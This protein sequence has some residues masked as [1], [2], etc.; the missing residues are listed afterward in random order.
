MGKKDIAL[1]KYLNDKERFS[2]LINGILFRGEQELMP[3]MLEERDSVAAIAVNEKRRLIKRE[4]D[5]IHKAAMGV[6]F[7]ILA[8]EN[9]M[10]IHY[11]MPVRIM[12]YDGITYEEQMEEL[13]KKNKIE[14]KYK[15]SAE[16]LSGMKKD[17]VL[18]PVITFVLYYG[19]DEWDDH[20]TLKSMLKIPSKYDILNTYIND[21]KV[22]LISMR[23]I[24]PKLFKGELREF[25]EL[26][27][28]NE[29]LEKMKQL[30]QTDSRYRFL[31]KDTCETLMALSD[32]MDYFERLRE[33]VENRE[34]FNMSTAFD[35][36]VQQGIDQ[37]M[38][39]GRKQQLQSQI[40]KKVE[41]G[42]SAEVIAEQLEED[43][44]TIV[45]LMKENE[46]N[47]TV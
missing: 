42:F 44:D 40:R 37:G 22:N 39:I 7:L 8:C 25:L 26:L 45:A 16:F 17:D 5:I 21:S 35:Q 4:R 34:V 18:I 23:K 31:T 24:D 12:L 2:D 1:R 20:L 29:D 3:S 6:E 13:R 11:G 19:K 28:C 47:F 30:V 32:G 38:E 27:Q 46:K 36:L 41:K 43:L 10:E 9:Q 33:C 15:N 14:N